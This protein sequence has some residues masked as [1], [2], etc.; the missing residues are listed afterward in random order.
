[1]RFTF[2][3]AVAV[4]LFN[5]ASCQNSAITIGSKLDR[6]QEKKKKASSFFASATEV[7][8]VQ[9]PDPEPEPEE[10][11]SDEELV[12]EDD[13]QSRHFMQRCEFGFEG[14]QITLEQ[15]GKDTPDR[16]IL[17]GS[18]KGKAMPGRMLAVMG[19]SG[20]GKSSLIHALAGRLSESSK[21]SLSG[22][23]KL[24][25]WFH[26]PFNLC[27]L[28]IS[29]ICCNRS[30]LMLLKLAT[31]ILI[32]SG[33][34]YVNGET[35]SEDSSLP[36][37]FIEQ[38][39][40]FFPHMT[41]KETLDFRVELKL[42]SR[43]GKSA[44]DDVVANL[45]EM[46]G[47][48]K[49]LNTIVGNSKVRGLSGGER[50]R[51]S[52]ACE[53]IS[54]PPVI[55]LDEPTSG[56]D[57]YQAAQVVETLRKLADSG[58]TIIAVIHQPSQSVFA[59]FDDLLLVSEGQLMYYGEVSKVRN[60]MKDL[61]YPCSKD[62]GTAEHVL[63]VISRTNGGAEEQENSTKRL[64]QLGEAAKASVEMISFGSGALVPGHKHHHKLKI[65]NQT[66]SPGAN[67]FRQFKLLLTRAFNETSRGKLAI[68]IKVVQQITL[69]LVYGGIYKVGDDQASIMD[70]FGLLSLI[71]IGGINMSVASTIRSFTREKSI[72]TGEM[73]NGMYRT[74]PYFLAKAISEIP[75]AGVFNT[76][77]AA[78]I[79][80][81][82]GLQKGKFKQFIGLTTLHA[83]AGEAAGLFIGAIAPSSDV[84]LSLFPAMIVLN[85]I[86]DGRNLSEEN[87][88]KLL[89]WLPKISLVRWGFEGLSVN[90]FNGLEF[91]AKGPRRG[92]I[93]KTGK[94]ALARFGF[95]DRKLGEVVNSQR[96]IIAGCWFLSYVGLSLTKSKFESMTAV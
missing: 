80:P 54:S 45:M 76:L 23:V 2:T 86:F 44:R 30:H 31:T 38:E 18:L 61:G 70:R 12:L 69:G 58:K 47:L 52:I 16:L 34:R 74:L 37:A 62:T 14:I 22:T 57:S 5:I 48:T 88:P 81:M 95:A 59:M 92:P 53:L 11:S 32:I 72:V 42:G 79:Y 24:F 29:I 10:S 82:A 4:S 6:P 26:V 27:L 89:R 15:K 50:K 84:A 87:T 91:S 28:A 64:N 36:A 46:L 39:V 67:I 71:A 35:L 8:L 60:Y 83:L 65:A 90:E 19:P 9:D 63:D 75:L 40:N 21:L 78:I 3:L 51:L 1:M 56:L 55:I 77:F 94:D 13:I 85:I 7:D 17:D 93:V 25:F 43:L 41:V 49:S 68:I 20:S 73:A 33:K 66:N 96:N